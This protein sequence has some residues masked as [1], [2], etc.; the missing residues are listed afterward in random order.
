MTLTPAP[1]PAHDPLGTPLGDFEAD[2]VTAN[3]VVKWR[4][5]LYR[6]RLRFVPP[7]GSLPYDVFRD[8]V[9]AKVQLID[10]VIM[11]R[12]LSVKL[13]KSFPLRV[14]RDAFTAVEAWVGRRRLMREMLRRRM[15]WL[16]F[17]GGMLVVVSVYST[18]GPDGMPV[19]GGPVARG[20]VEPFT[21]SLGLAFIFAW[22][23]VRFRPRRWLF[24]LD[25]ML[26]GIMAAA[27]AAGLARGWRWFPFAVFLMQL[28]LAISAFRAWRRFKGVGAD[29]DP[30]LAE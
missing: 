13:H 2:E 16:I 14:S 7:D 22:L 20:P 21:L 10:A 3:P 26:F 12:T 8:D 4:V 6:D 5:M 17:F 11:P 29:D 30:A 27:T 9:A 15:G 25:A 1:I 19:T 28:M 24:A 23:L 18:R